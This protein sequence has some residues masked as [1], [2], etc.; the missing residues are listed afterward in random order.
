MKML[1]AGFRVT[2]VP[3]HEYRRQHGES[4]I[5]IWRQWPLFVFC[6]LTHVLRRSRPVT[7]S[8]DG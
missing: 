6:V 2:N 1:L 3:T 8:L 7:S 4:H 5:R